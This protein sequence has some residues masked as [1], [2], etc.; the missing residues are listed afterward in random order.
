MFLLRSYRCFACVPR[1][2]R[3][4]P[5]R[6]AASNPNEHLVT[7]YLAPVICQPKPGPHGLQHRPPRRGARDGCPRLSAAGRPDPTH[8]APRS[9][10]TENMLLSFFSAGLGPGGRGS[11]PETPLGHWTC[12]F[13]PRSTRVVCIRRLNRETPRCVPIKLAE[14]FLAV[15]PGAI[16]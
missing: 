2:S 5:A 13:C 11:R 15:L 1:E 4:V 6:E 9:P 16:P 3:R 12:G 14:G 8:E 7:E 10:R